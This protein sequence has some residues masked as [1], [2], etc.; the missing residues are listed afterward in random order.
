MGLL[1]LFCSSPLFVLANPVNIRYIH[2]LEEWEVMSPLSIVKKKYIYSI[3]FLYLKLHVNRCVL[4]SVLDGW[5]GNH[6][7]CRRGAVYKIKVTV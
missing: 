7:N 1:A 5:M 2:V 6:V 4:Q 3:L